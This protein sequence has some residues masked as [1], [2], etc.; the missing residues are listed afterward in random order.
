MCQ[1]LRR[2]VQGHFAAGFCAQSHF[3]RVTLA[4]RTDSTEHSRSA[5][6][7]SFF[8]WDASR[9]KPSLRKVPVWVPSY[10]DRNL[11]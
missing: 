6:G 11:H 9:E 2:P 1:P 3:P 10:A 5:V 8:V 7:V 4:F